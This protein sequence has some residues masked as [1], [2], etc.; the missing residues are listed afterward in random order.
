MI[1][2]ASKNNKGFVLIEMLVAIAMFMIIIVSIT[3]LS[4]SAIRNQK[5]VLANQEISGQASYAFEYIS[6][7]LR[8]AQKDSAGNCVSVNGNY[9]NPLGSSSVRFLNHS[10]K[11]QEFYLDGGGEL[12]EKKSTDATQ[13][14]FGTGTALMSDHITI[15]SLDFHLIGA[16]NTDNLQPRVVI[17]L[18]AQAA[19]VAGTPRLRIQ[20]TVSQRNLDL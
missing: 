10:G 6:R 15:T 2:M 16:D 3:S 8:M 1:N 12:K 9:T 14:G 17:V 7:A 19:S 13:G 11:C 18:D 5:M 4:V 20:T